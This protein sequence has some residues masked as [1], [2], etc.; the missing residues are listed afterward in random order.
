MLCIESGQAQSRKC[1]Y[2]SALRR[3]LQH[4]ITKNLDLWRVIS[5]YTFL[6]LRCVAHSL[7]DKMT[8]TTHQDFGANT[9]ALEVAKVFADSVRGKTVIITGV[10]RKGIG[11]TTAEAFVS[12]MLISVVY[13]RELTSCRHLSLPR[14]SFSP[15]AP[16]PSCRS[17]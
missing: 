17:P 1:V 3:Q 12:L 13:P 6:H 16:C 4:S 10:N 14:M 2:K 11:Y 8:S 5:L 7:F 15:A 9:E